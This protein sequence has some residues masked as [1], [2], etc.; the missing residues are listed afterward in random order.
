MGEKVA[1]KNIGDNGVTIE[2]AN[3]HELVMDLS[4]FTPE[5]VTQLALHGLSQK[6]GDSYS[7][8]KGDVEEAIG[9]ATG[10]F[11]RLQ[12]GE[13]R[14]S[15]EGSGG[16]G[17]VSDLARA[18]AKVAGVELSDAVAK[19]AEMDKEG[20][21]GLKDNI[22]IQKAL[23]EIAEEK[24]KAKQAELDAKVAEADP[25]DLTAMFS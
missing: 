23:N 6:V 20:K 22:H 4:A 8:V 10:V 9:L 14:A 17:R 7:G 15:R 13:F 12:N 25:G 19:L 2:F 5:I 21:K 11:T 16:G 18:L 3:G 1:S 24:L